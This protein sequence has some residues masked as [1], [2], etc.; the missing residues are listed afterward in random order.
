ML[1][2]LPFLFGPKIPGHDPAWQIL[3]N[4]KQIGE[5]VVTPV[6]NDE[7]IIYLE[8]K[9]EVEAKHSFLKKLIKH[10]SCFKNVSLSLA[11]K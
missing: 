10:T 7:S 3:L 8:S 5:L 6:Y 9:H 11:V 1:R 2:L 4:L